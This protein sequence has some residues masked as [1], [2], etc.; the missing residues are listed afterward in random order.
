MVRGLY[1]AAMGMMASQAQVDTISQNLAN[2]NT[3][4]YCKDETLESSFPQMMLSRLDSN[5]TAAVGPA[6]TGNTIAGT[7]TSFDEGADQETGDPL[8]V[9]LHGNAFFTVQDGQG[10]TYYTRNG[11]FALNQQGQLITNAGDAVLGETGG[12]QEAIFVPDGKLVVAKDGSLS[13]AVDAQGQA[14]D[15]LL[16]S[17]KPSTAAWSKVGNSLFSGQ[18]QNPGT[19]YSVQQG[20]SEESNVNP[21]DEMVKLIDASRAY[22]ANAKVIQ[23]TDETLNEVANNVGNVNS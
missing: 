21:V 4:G 23:A 13:G 16:L 7:Y 15:G 5:G 10:Q 11:D 20:Y 8:N 2:V 6:G 22:E 18:A 9:A 3:S 17:S 1:T 12:Q 14:V 19:D